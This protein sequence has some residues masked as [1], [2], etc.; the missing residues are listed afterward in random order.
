MFGLKTSCPRCRDW[1]SSRSPSGVLPRRLP[2][3][4]R[5][6]PSPVTAGMTTIAPRTPITTPRSS[7][8]QR[9]GPDYPHGRI[10]AA[11]PGPPTVRRAPGTPRLPC[12]ALDQHTPRSAHRS[13]STP[14][15]PPRARID[16]KPLEEPCPNSSPPRSIASLRLPAA[17][18]PSCCL[19][20][21]PNAPRSSHLGVHPA[22]R[23][24]RRDPGAGPRH[25]PVPGL[26]TPHRHLRPA[27]LPAERFALSALVGVEFVIIRLQRPPRRNR[28]SAPGR[29]TRHRVD[30]GLHPVLLGTLAFVAAMLS[31]REIPACRSSS[32]LS[33]PSHL[34]TSLCP[35]GRAGPR[36]RYPCRRRRLARDLALTPP[37][38]SPPPP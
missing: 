14:R 36:A 21:P 6:K 13:V 25:R 7:H 23:P 31:T 9:P 19:S 30:H 38:T 4:Q 2:G 15:S 27:R 3:R 33:A 26:R 35:R 10:G 1:P 28:T 22:G 5:L 8:R 16:R 34:A 24:G 32:T 37:T 12:S 20:T 29:L 17:A 11:L 18:A